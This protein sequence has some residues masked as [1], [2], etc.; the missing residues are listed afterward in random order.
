MEGLGNQMTWPLSGGRGSS[1]QISS[2]NCVRHMHAHRLCTLPGLIY[3]GSNSSRSISPSE[4]K[5]T[6][7]STAGFC[8]KQCVGWVTEVRLSCYLVLLS[9]DSK[10]R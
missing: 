7:T 6:E 9:T 1:H 8:T 5:E 4:R 10:T 2:S 3:G